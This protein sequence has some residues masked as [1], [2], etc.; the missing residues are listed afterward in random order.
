MARAIVRKPSVLILDDCMDGIDRETE[1]DILKR[2]RK[3]QLTV[4]FM[5]KKVRNAQN[6][7]KIA[8]LQNGRVAEEGTHSELMD[9]LNGIYKNSLSLK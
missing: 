5:C 9:R 6:F 2:L 3:E 7:E 4:I 8:V 1:S